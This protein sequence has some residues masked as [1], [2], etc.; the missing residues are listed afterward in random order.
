MSR[1]FPH[2]RAVQIEQCDCAC[3]SH[4]I[5]VNDAASLNF[6]NIPL[7]ER[8]GPESGV[9]ILARSLETPLL[10]SWIQVTD[11]CNMAC[12]YCYSPSG[13]DDLSAGVGYAVIDAIFRSAVTHGYQGVKIKYAGGEPLLRFPLVLE[14][15]KRARLLARRHGL[16]LDGVVLS[17]GT[18]LTADKVEMMRPCGLRL[19]ISLD[20][21]GE[22]HNCQRHYCDGGDTFKDV[23]DGIDLAVAGDIELCISIT[24]SGRNAKGLPEVVAWALERRLPFSLNFYRENDRS[25]LQSDLD[26]EKVCIIEGMLAAYKVIEND[27]PDYCLLTALIDRANLATPH[28]HTCSAGRDYL[29]FDA[30][31]R[32]VK[33][34]MDMGNPVSDCRDPDPLGKV[35]SD[36]AGFQNPRVT[37]KAECRDCQWRYWCGGGCPLQAFRATGRYTSKSPHCNIYRVLFPQV[38]RL[39]EL[40]LN[41]R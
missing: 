19:M 17:N 27:L 7:I 6:G 34:Q 26:L 36:T 8:D 22:S 32:V 29:V 15:H 39:E 20:G 12:D 1:T 10:S 25:V 3:A 35:R 4:L 21:L 23:I 33:C 9:G 28:L 41:A 40:R 14:L 13:T 16:R 2:P 37:D 5:N 18:L 11:A 30:K 31:G 38:L 24:I